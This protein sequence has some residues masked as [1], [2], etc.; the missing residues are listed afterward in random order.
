MYLTIL[1]EL[2]AEF[3]NNRETK[4]GI[5]PYKRIQLYETT[6]ICFYIMHVIY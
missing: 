5:T 4:S 1:L 3:I 2:K 6:K